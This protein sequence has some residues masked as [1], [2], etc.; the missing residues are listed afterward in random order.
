[1]GTS[2]EYPKPRSYLTVLG[3]PSFSCTRATRTRSPRLD[4]ASLRVLRP[5]S[6][7]IR[8]PRD[9]M[10]PPVCIMLCVFICLVSVCGSSAVH[11][12]LRPC[13]VFFFLEPRSLFQ[14][15]GC[16]ECAFVLEL[17]LFTYVLF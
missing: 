12:M 9:A 16:H 13:L 11:R 7:V 5:T 1:M 4:T 3:A 8:R 15:G 2:L 14:M 17:A 6:S 10:M